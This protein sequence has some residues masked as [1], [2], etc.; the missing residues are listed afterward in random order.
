[1]V[2]V[3]EKVSQTMSDGSREKFFQ[4]A[5]EE[6]DRESRDEREKE[7][8]CTCTINEDEFENRGDSV[9][10]AKMEKMTS[11]RESEPKRETS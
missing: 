3:K 11:E 2:E 10:G 8:M 5:T 7:L 6:I 1:M 9:K 4:K